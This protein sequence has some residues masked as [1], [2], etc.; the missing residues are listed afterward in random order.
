MEVSDKGVFADAAVR[1]GDDVL[2]VCGDSLSLVALACVQT[3]GAG[4]SGVGDAIGRII[5]YK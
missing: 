4:L 5:N 1:E 3:N 2:F